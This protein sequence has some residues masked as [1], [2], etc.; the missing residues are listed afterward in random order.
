MHSW[1]S[2][3]QCTPV[4]FLEWRRV[5]MVMRQGVQVS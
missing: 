3:T 5:E 2:G 4:M 1:K